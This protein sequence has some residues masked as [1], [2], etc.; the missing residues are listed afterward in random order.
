MHN[1]M[2][3]GNDFRITMSTIETPKKI[4]TSE[5]CFLCKAKISSEEMAV[6]SLILCATEV[7]LSVCV[8]NNLVAVDVIIVCFAIRE[9]WIE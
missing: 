8:G 4:L 1:I 6:H 7:D 9:L 2:G 3:T 5:V